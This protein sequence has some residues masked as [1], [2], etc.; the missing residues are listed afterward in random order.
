MVDASEALGGG[1]KAAH[2]NIRKKLEGY[3]E[4]EGDQQRDHLQLTDFGTKGY[5]ESKKSGHWVHIT[6]PELVINEILKMI[7]ELTRVD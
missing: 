1:T 6:E 2:E 4:L 5:L 3:S 7:G